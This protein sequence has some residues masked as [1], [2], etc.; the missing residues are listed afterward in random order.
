METYPADNRQSVPI[1]AAFLTGRDLIGG[2][3]RELTAVRNNRVL[4]AN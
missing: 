1:L 2:A 4:L 3:T